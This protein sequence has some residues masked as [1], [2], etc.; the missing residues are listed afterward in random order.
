MSS[1][2]KKIKLEHQGEN[3]TTADVS[4]SSTQEDQPTADRQQDLRDLDH[5][6]LEHKVNI[7]LS[8]A[9]EQCSV[10]DSLQISVYWDTPQPKK[11]IQLHW[12]LRQDVGR[13]FEAS[14]E[15]RWLLLEQYLQPLFRLTRLDTCPIKRKVI[16]LIE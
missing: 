2:E 5:N 15:I 16:A 1:A 9:V 12:I 7:L 11:S 8:F 3:S 6:D 13:T 10:G 14:L 4:T